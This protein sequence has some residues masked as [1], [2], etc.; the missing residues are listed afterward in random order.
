MWSAY[1]A[2]PEVYPRVCGGTRLLPS[3]MM[4]PKGLSPRVRGNPP[5]HPGGGGRQGSIPACAGEPTTAAPATIRATVYPRVCGG[6]REPGRDRG[7][8]A[9]LSPRVR[10]NR[11]GGGGFCRPR[12]SIPACAGEPRVRKS[13]Y[14]ASGVY[15]R[16]CGGTGWTRG[17]P[18]RRPGLSPRVRGNPCCDPTAENPRGSIPACAGEPSHLARLGAREQVYPRV[19][20]GTAGARLPA[21]AGGGLSPRVRGNPW[22]EPR[23][24]PSWGSIPACAGEPSCG[25]DAHRFAGVYPRVCG[26]TPK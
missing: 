6:T 7:A 15:P 19:C 1:R 10:G 14:S 4:R 26:G 20:G 5:A 3:L 17:P 23:S 13:A 25:A 22:K 16:V 9:G 11:P 12:G 8:R 18:P 21:R 2:H 24:T